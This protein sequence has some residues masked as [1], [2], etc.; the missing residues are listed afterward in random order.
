MLLHHLDALVASHGEQA[1]QRV[2]LTRSDHLYACDHPSPPM[3]PGVVRVMD[4]KMYHGVTD[5]HQLFAFADRKRVLS[6]LPWLASRHP[7][8]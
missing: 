4:G 3:E 1:Y 5:R 2:L 8:S 7:T 6:I